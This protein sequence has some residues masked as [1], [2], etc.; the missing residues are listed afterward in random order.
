MWHTFGPGFQVF[1]LS[2][3][4]KEASIWIGFLFSKIALCFWISS[5][6]QKVCVR[7]SRRFFP[8]QVLILGS[9]LKPCRSQKFKVDNRFR[10]AR[11]NAARKGR[12][13]AST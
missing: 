11:E 12:K 10:Q 4:V 8:K 5:G 7:N 6:I 13:G 9:L 1:G 3:I 2:L